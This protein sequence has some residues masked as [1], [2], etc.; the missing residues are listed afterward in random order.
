MKINIK[1]SRV[2]I[3]L[4]CDHKSGILYIVPSESSWVCKDE[5]LD[6]H[7]LSGFFSD[8]VESG[9]KKTM[10]LMQKWG[11]YY[12]NNPFTEPDESNDI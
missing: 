12:R 2:K 3:D 6:S 1:E 10:R 7:S 11:V 4:E 8:I 9:D 5:N